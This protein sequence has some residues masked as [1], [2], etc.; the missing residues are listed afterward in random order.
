MS[1]PI[2]FTIFGE[3]ASKANS[4]KLVYNPRTKKPMFIKSQKA[5]KYEKDFQLQCR[6]LPELITD[7]V[8]VTATI[9]YATRRPDL[10]ESVI[11][12]CMQGYIYV[13]DRQVKKKVIT[14]GLDRD[15]PRSE[16]QVERL[17]SD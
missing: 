7:D 4:R 16:I 14:W 17:A 6:K 1:T 11:L 9:F 12:D 10:D 2:T 15:N 8:C 13:N 3:P 5:R